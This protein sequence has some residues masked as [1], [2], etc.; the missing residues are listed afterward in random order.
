MTLRSGGV[1]VMTADSSSSMALR[2][3]AGMIGG[4]PLKG[5]GSDGPAGRSASGAADGETGHDEA[6]ATAQSAR[7]NGARGGATGVFR[8]HPRQA[9][10]TD[11]IFPFRV[12]AL[13][14]LTM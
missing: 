1:I 4:A 2:S 14:G 6:R 10:K 9:W 11:S 13:N 12:C 5:A 8:S 7:R 3:G